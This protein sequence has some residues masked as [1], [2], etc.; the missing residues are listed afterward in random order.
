MFEREARPSDSRESREYE[1]RERVS[2]QNQ[3]Q[4][5]GHFREKNHTVYHSFS[6][7]Q[8]GSE[9]FVIFDL[10]PS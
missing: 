10:L 3:V 8:K 9:P 4:G 5:P 2:K 1:V 6:Q 7:S